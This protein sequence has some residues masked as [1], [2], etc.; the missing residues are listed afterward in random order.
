MWLLRQYSKQFPLQQ[1]IEVKSK[2]SGLR[3]LVML[4]GYNEGEKINTK[5][6]A[7]SHVVEVSKSGLISIMG[8]KWTIFR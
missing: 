5:D 3:P 2:W 1:N 7:R 4:E 6:V 8:G